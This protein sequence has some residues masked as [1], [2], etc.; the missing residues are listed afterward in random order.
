MCNQ[1]LGYPDT[2]VARSAN[3][4][5]IMRSICGRCAILPTSHMIS[6]GLEITSEHPVQSGGFADVFQGTLKGALVAIKVFRLRSS[7][8]LDKMKVSSSD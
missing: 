1:I 2:D 3:C 4:M 8:R 5:G 6:D 7:D